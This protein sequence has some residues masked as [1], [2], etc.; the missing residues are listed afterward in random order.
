MA[1][2]IKGQRDVVKV[3]LASGADVTAISVKV[4]GWE[5]EGGEEPVGGRKGSGEGGGGG[6]GR[7]EEAVG[8][9]IRSYPYMT[10]TGH[11]YGDLTKYPMS[12]IAQCH[13]AGR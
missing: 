9:C 13:N 3:L 7:G 10:L 8:V 1:A 2:A 11:N 12:V 5:R 6:G 4:G